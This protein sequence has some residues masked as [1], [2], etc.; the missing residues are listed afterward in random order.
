MNLRVKLKSFNGTVSAPRDC[1][2]DENYWLLIGQ[3]GEIIA[4]ANQ[5]HRV[6]VRFE[7]LVSSFGL[8]CHNEIPNSL[9]ILEADLEIVNEHGRIETT[10]QPGRLE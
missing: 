1:K 8:H 5:Q 2:P 6:L 10:A 4:P 7:K 3:A 9:L